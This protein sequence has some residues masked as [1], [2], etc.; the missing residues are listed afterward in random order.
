MIDLKAQPTLRH[1]MKVQAGLQGDKTAIWFEGRETSY[2][3]L[4]ERSNQVGN[5][6][7]AEGCAK[8]ARVGFI[9]KNSDHNIEVIMGTFAAGT[10]LVGVNW[11]L[12]GPEIEYVLKDAGVEVLFVDP[13]FE[14]VIGQVAGNV[15]TL[16]KIIAMGGNHADW[17]GYE[18]WRDQF[19]T[20]DTDITIE[21]EDDVIQLYTSGTTG[22]PKG[23]Q[24]TNGNYQSL[25]DGAVEAGWADWN[26]GAGNLVCMP[27]FHVAGVNIAIL[28]LAQGCKNIVIADVDPALIIDLIQEH[29]IETC[30]MVPAVILFVMQMPN[31]EGAD[32][33]SVRMVIYGAS[34]IAEDLLVSAQKRFE[35]DFVQVYGLTETAGGG[36][37]LPPEA[38]DPALG[39]LRSC[40]KAVPGVEIRID[41]G[42][43][44]EQPTGDV[45]E[46]LIRSGIIMKGYWNR[47]EATAEAIDGDG[48]F[49]TGDAGY[50]DDEG[51]IYIHDRVKDMI[52]SGG[53]NVYPAEVENALFGH[54]DIADVAV[55]GV[56]DEKWGEAVK[57]IVVAEP[58]K[59][60]DPADVITFA[61]ERI[62]GYKCPKTV[63][64]I[65]ALPRNPSGKILRRELRAPYWEGHDRQVG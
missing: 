27:N 15:P 31:L 20:E 54:P 5:G 48:W 53:E 34:P 29:S 37:F 65:E 44:G 41:D 1:I 58:G 45:G 6:L 13:D 7:I 64:F 38:H 40:G 56:P 62:A 59:T 32:L 11:R 17:Q 39:K 47:A 28:G 57:A 16:R 2:Q 50:K 46:I 18:A 61:K 26:A 30:F 55:V 9:G 21:D 14:D 3:T 8:N 36:T 52:V 24:L 35:C 51:Y 4:Y 42:K 23:V 12:A 43:G 10:V 60:L 63:D 49:H 25:L 22:H 19:G 33:S